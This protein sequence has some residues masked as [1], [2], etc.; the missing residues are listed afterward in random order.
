MMLS[1]QPLS[2]ET[3]AAQNRQN[4][5]SDLILWCRQATLSR[6]Q[7]GPRVDRIKARTLVNDRNSAGRQGTVATLPVMREAG[8]GLPLIL[9]HPELWFLAVATPVLKDEP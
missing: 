5:L 4:V 9:D 3:P 8:S 1:I 2:R 6:L 7:Y